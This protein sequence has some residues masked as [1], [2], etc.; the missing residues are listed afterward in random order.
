MR[1]KRTAALFGAT[2]SSA[3]AAQQPSKADDP[4]EVVCRRPVADVSSRIPPRKDCRT[5]AQWAEE[6]RLNQ[7]TWDRRQRAPATPRQ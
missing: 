2:I 1:F 4:N 3:L 5:R 7:T 6:A